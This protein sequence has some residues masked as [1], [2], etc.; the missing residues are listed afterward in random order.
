M[1]HIGRN[2]PCP[3]GS[4]KK[5][6]KCC[7]DKDQIEQRAQREVQKMLPMESADAWRDEPDACDEVQEWEEDPCM[8]EFYSR[9]DTA[10]F[11][12]RLVMF[13]EIMSQMQGTEDDLFDIFDVLQESANDDMAR[14]ELNN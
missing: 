13:R 10:D 6:K 2:E 12:E 5:Y 9:F 14:R 8:E 4:G 7:L 3:C 11:A 1:S